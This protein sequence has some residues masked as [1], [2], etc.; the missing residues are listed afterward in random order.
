M[1]YEIIGIYVRESGVETEVVSCNLS[2]EE[3][4]MLLGDLAK[5]PPLKSVQFSYYKR[6]QNTIK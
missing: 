5:Q 6:E 1:Q 2:E 4:D 3:A